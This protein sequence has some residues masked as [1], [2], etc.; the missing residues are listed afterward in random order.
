[1]TTRSKPAGSKAGNQ[2]GTFKVHYCSPAQAKFIQ[3]LLDSRIHSMAITDAT[4]V[5]KKHATRII[6]E[7][8]ACPKKFTEPVTEKQISFMMLLIK[9]RQNAD[10]VCNTKLVA[11]G[12][13]TIYKLDRDQAK[14]FINEFLQL[15]KLPPEIVEIPVGAYKMNDTFY[16]VRKSRESGRF[17]AYAY[18]MTTKRW[19]FDRG[20]INKITPDMRL[21]LSDASAFGIAT[22]TCVHCARTLTVQKSVVA[23]MGRVCASKYN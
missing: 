21:T 22:G 12:L 23:G 16:S 1:M 3:S 7:L 17:H 5:N 13:S 2:Y 19:N 11:L 14:I 10:Q 9:T 8:L 15:P 18:D 6:K 4:T 20:A